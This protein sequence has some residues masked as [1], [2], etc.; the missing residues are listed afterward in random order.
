ML[1]ALSEMGALRGTSE[2]DAPEHPMHVTG[3]TSTGTR[4]LLAVIAV[5]AHPTEDA[6]DSRM[7]APAS[8]ARRDGMVAMIQGI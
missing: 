7:T 4:A 2:E 6:H 3:P 8:R 1:R 5:A